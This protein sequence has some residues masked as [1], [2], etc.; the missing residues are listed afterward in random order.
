MWNISHLNEGSEIIIKCVIFTFLSPRIIRHFLKFIKHD[1][2]FME[3]I[4]CNMNKK[5]AFP[6]YSQG[7]AYIINTIKMWTCLNLMD[8]V[9]KCILL[10]NLKQKTNAYFEKVLWE[11]LFASVLCKNSF[12]KNL[13]NSHV[14]SDQCAGHRITFKE[15]KKILFTDLWILKTWTWIFRQRYVFFL[16]SNL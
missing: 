13:I 14:Q 5:S 4:L 7:L 1:S 6:F 10:L 3:N 15:K 11:Y 2:H 12:G 16:L 9:T 8:Y